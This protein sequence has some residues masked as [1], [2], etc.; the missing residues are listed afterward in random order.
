MVHV[1][2][3]VAATGRIVFDGTDVLGSRTDRLAGLGIAHVPQGRGT[4]ADF[5]VEEN[6][7]HG[8][9]TRRDRREIEREIQ[10]WYDFFPRIGERRRERA[11]NLSGGEQQML[12][13]ARALMLRPRLL[14]L[15]EPSL[16]LAPVVRAELFGALRGINA[17][18]GTTMLIVEQDAQ[19]A[20]DIATSA[21]VLEAGRIV[22][23]HD[24]G[25]VVADET[26]RLAHLRY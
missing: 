16:G 1:S 4:S 20:L 8:A 6:L 18:T 19:L 9:F 3:M 25:S 5:T 10:S 2:G 14:L 17:D 24:A 21:Y 12:A 26:L 13:V 22:A 23:S 15:D 7:A 11:G